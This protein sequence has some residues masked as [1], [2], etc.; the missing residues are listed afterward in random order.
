MDTGRSSECHGHA[1]ASLFPALIVQKYFQSKGIVTKLGSL[2]LF[3]EQEEVCTFGC[4]LGNDIFILLL[5]TQLFWP[6]ELF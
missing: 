6:L 4:P 2:R 5:S 1:F 3:L